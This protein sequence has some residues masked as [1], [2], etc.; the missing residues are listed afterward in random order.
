MINYKDLRKSTNKYREL[1]YNCFHSEYFLGFIGGV[2]KSSYYFYGYD[3]NN[4]YLLYLDPHFITDYNPN[5][6]YNQKL[7]AKNYQIVFIDNI[8]PSITF[9]F[10]YRNYDSFLKLKKFLETKTIFNILNKI[11]ET[12]YLNK[13]NNKKKVEDNEEWEII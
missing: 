4:N 1:I 7:L 11:D 3:T 5:I 8:N 2:G 13:I 10:Y 12:Q 9:C 6:K